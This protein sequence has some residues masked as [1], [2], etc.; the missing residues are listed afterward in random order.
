M[1]NA[2]RRPIKDRRIHVYKTMDE[3][4]DEAIQGPW[5]YGLSDYFCGVNSWRKLEKLARDGWPDQVPEMMDCTEKAV[6]LIEQ[7]IEMFEPVHSVEGADVDIARF[8]EGE[9][10][11][12]I[13][14]PLVKTSNLGP[15]V[16]IVADISC[17]CTVTTANKIQRGAVIGSLAITLER[18][19]HNTEFW[20]ASRTKVGG[21]VS[22]VF[23]KV[24]GANDFIDPSRIMFAAAH[25]ASFRGL[26]FNICGN[27]DNPA[28]KKYTE[29]EYDIFGGGYERRKSFMGTRLYH[30]GF[31]GNEDLPHDV[32]GED[33]I[34][35]P[36]IEA[37]DGAP[38]AERE[39]RAFLIQIGLIRGDIEDV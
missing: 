25:P 39:L 14:Y 34:Y 12:M 26:T 31:G 11:D 4:T 16:K 19:G 15:L 20:V 32:I 7:D 37:F 8:L 27:E 33:A 10:E 6:K 29:D 35:L 36:M 5:M 38:N 28:T 18:L 3:L 21:E 30:G 17:L 9:P 1:A 23:C 22:D 24:K 13:Q 2:D